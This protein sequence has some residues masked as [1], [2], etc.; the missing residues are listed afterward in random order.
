MNAQPR[1]GS[2]RHGTRAAVMAP[3]AQ[4]SPCGRA[5]VGQMASESSSETQQTRGPAQAS[6]HVMMTVSGTASFLN[7]SSAM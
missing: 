7:A 1:A 4:L 5:L 3:G 2:G 6:R